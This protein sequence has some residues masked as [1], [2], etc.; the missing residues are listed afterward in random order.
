MWNVSVTGA[1]RL[2]NNIKE[3]TGSGPNIYFVVCW[4]VLSPLLILV[5]RG[6]RRGASV[7]QWYRAGLLVNR[8]SV[9]TILHQGHDS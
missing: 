3:M 4:Y 2:A 7:V 1:R 8:S 6:V 9:Q 5:S